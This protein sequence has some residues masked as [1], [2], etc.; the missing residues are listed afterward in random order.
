MASYNNTTIKQMTY[1][2]QKVKNWYHDGVKIFSAGNMV[3]YYVNTNTSYQEEVDSEASC[4]SPT[5]F[6]PTISGWTFV[7]WREDTTASGSVLSSKIMGDEPITLYAVFKRTLTAT[8]NGNGATSGSVGTVYGTQYYNNNNYANPSI[9]LP[10]NGFGRTNYKFTGWNLGAVGASV[11]I[12]ADTTVYA[13][14][15]ASVYTYGYE[16]KVATFTAPIAGRYLLEVWGAQGGSGIASGGAGGYS[17]GYVNLSAGQV[18]YI[19]VGGA[20]SNMQKASHKVAAGGYN[21][22]GQGKDNGAYGGGGG[23]GCTHIGTRA[24]ALRDYG[25]TS[26]LLIVAGGGGGGGSTYYGD[27]FYGNGGS[28]GG[29]TGESS[30]Y[31]KA[32][33]GTQSSAGRPSDM[34][35]G[36]GY[37]GYCDVYGQPGGGGGLYGGGSG[38]GGSGYIGGVSGGSTANGQRSGNGYARISIA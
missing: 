28:G 27:Q 2:G 6:T 25:N 31:N 7:G 12:S 19:V 32:T 29:L 26:G 11:V 18:L 38:A 33:G 14:W 13:Q 23:G 4:L 8:F 5:T 9:T 30:K 36:F 21:G 24:G 37:G 16:G 1:K 22:G 20:G 34:P 3:T 17:K 10:A 35:S 15:V